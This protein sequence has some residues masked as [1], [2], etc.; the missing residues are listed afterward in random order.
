MDEFNRLLTEYKN[1]YLQF[2]STGNAEYKTA[3]ER[4][5]KGIEDAISKKREQVDSQKKSMSHFLDSY[6][7]DNQDI[8]KLVNNSE[9]ITK[10]AQ[11]LHDDYE[12][13]K[14]RYDS[15]TSDPNVQKGPVIDVTNGYGIMLRIGIFLILLPI[16]IFIGYYGG[17]RAIQAAT[18]AA[19]SPGAINIHQSPFFGPQALHNR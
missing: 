18:Q 8:S 10:D 1:Q 5:M 7:K 4:V 19:S 9:E 12:T 2:L 15:W 16:L 13:S 11:A 14:D 6:K 3:Y 17:S